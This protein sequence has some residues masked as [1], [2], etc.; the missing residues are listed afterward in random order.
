MNRAYLVLD[1]ELDTLDGGGGG[2]RDG[3]RDTTH[4]ISS[5]YAR[6]HG[7]S[8]F[9]AWASIPRPIVP[10]IDGR[11]DVDGD[12]LKKSTTKPCAYVS[13]CANDCHS[14]RISTRGHPAHRP[15]RSVISGCRRDALE[16]SLG[17][18]EM[19][20]TLSCG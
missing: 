15:I 20:L 18:I 17:A 1:E 8:G 7:K 2:L 5:Q 6:F 12:V 3:G 19:G 14:Y 13:C 9:V 4:C 16:T 10:V 11:C